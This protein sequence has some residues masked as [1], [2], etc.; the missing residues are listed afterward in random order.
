[1]WAYDPGV[2][3]WPYDPARAAR[4]LDEAGWTSPPEGGLR[5]RGG[6]PFR[7]TLLVPAGNQ[8]LERFAA[9]LQ[10][11]L[12]QLSVEMEIR[13]LEFSLLRRLRD[14]GQFEAILGGWSLDPDPDCYDFWHSSQGG[15]RGLNHASYADAE[16][17]SLC[18]AARRTLSI[19]ERTTLYHRVQTILHRDQPNTFIAYRRSLT[20][21]S[22]RLAGVEPSPLGLWGWYPGPLLWRLE[23]AASP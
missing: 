15:G 23:E 11:S 10:E 6:R 22:R 18:E 17:D 4:L 3:P 16:V 9:I 21:T 20:G 2:A 5:A 12:R 14:S 13:S 19:P 1:M 8:E 7:F